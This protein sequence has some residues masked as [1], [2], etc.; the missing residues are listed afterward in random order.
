LRAQLKEK[1]DGCNNLESEIVYL[2]KKLE[3]SNTNMKFEK[4]STTLDEIQN[5]QRSPLDKTNL[6]YSEKNET[7][8]EVIQEDIHTRIYYFAHHG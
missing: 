2:R 5:C 7:T 4:S 6:G 1:E 3:K 8:K